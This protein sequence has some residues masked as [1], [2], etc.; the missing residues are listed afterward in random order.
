[1]QS[2]GAR[3]ENHALNGSICSLNAVILRINATLDLDAVLG[4]VVECQKHSIV[5]FPA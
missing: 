4:E 5:V 2:D 1:M 3:W